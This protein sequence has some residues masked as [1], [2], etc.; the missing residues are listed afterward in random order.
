MT[1]PEICL[2][3]VC[4]W[5]TGWMDGRI[6][7]DYRK[8]SFFFFCQKTPYCA[9]TCLNK[10]INSNRQFPLMIFTAMVNVCEWL[11]LA[12]N[13]IWTS[14]FCSCFGCR[15]DSKSC[16]NLPPT[17]VPDDTYLST[18]IIQNTIEHYTTLNPLQESFGAGFYINSL[19]FLFHYY[20]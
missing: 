1:K 12:E 10:Q 8:T 5:F 11:L 19:I 4:P 16:P 20:T 2:H 3:Y 15:G 7:T 13:C 6:S 14:V 9:L 18:G 17:A